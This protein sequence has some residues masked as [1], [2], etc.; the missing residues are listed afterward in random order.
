MKL[1]ATMKGH[2]S[3][4]AKVR[5]ILY[6]AYTTSQLLSQLISFD[7]LFL[8]CGCDHLVGSCIVAMQQ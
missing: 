8:V 2:V 1:V 5:D 4:V 3:E 7:K 6:I